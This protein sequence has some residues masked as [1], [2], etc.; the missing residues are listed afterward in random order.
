MNEVLKVLL[1][2]DSTVDAELIL[3][4]LSET[5]YQVDQ[6]LV[7]NALE[8]RKLLSERQWD[9]VL[10]D[11]SMPGFN[12]FEA[13][14]ILREFNIDIPFIVISGTIGEENVIKLM[15]AGCHDCIMKFNMTRLPGVI[16]REIE[17][18]RIK[19]ENRTLKERLQKYQIL[20]EKAN[21]AMFFVDKEGNILEVNDAAIKTYG[22]T[23]K[24]DFEITQNCPLFPF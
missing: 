17:E 21:D 24:G 6:G 20:A 8:M 16:S 7:D 13:L 22:Y 5:G 19:K 1:V 3:D 15:K 11:Y 23:Q 18:A 10:C 4:K 9:I 12:P 2:E 14:N